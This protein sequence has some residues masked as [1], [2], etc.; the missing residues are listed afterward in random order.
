MQIAT[1]D[2]AA[3]Q[4]VLRRWLEASGHEVTMITNITDIDDK[5][6][7]KSAE[8]GHAWWAHAFEF[9][10]VFHRAYA[11]LGIL[12]PTYEP[13]ATGH[14]PEMIGLIAELIERCRDPAIEEVVLA[15]GAT[16]EGQTT[17]HYV[18][19]QLARLGEETG[20]RLTVTR[21]AHGVPVGGELDYLDDGTLAQAIRARTRF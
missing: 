4:R 8:A 12:P 9:E 17:A 6:L 11:A 5:I 2:E 20:R 3:A 1:R 7:I 10:G 19:E 14:V 15:V 21:L 18:G 16:V 13:R